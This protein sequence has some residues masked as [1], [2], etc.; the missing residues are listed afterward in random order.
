MPAALYFYLEKLYGCWLTSAKRET[1]GG[2]LKIAPYAEEN[3]RDN[4]A[5]EINPEKITIEQSKAAHKI[6]WNKQEKSQPT[7][8]VVDSTCV[9]L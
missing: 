5:L 8:G 7:G 3:H 2:Y 6:S 4:Y 9:F 1:Q